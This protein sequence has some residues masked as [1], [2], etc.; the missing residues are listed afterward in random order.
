[1]AVGHGRVHVVLLARLVHAES[2]K[3]D[4]SSG[5]VLGLHVTRDVDRG[6]RAELL[7]AVLHHARFEGDGAG[8]FDGATE[9]DLRVALGKVQ[10]TDTELGPF[11]MDG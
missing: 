3:G 10:I 11:D 4:E 6:G 9:R 8:H 2:L 1:M 7:H 5:A